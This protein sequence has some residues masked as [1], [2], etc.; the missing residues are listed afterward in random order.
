MF[1]TDLHL[2]RAL[3]AKTQSKPLALLQRYGEL[4]TQQEIKADGLLVRAE[5]AATDNPVFE[6]PR[7]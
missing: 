5:F 3:K 1:M 4:G 2:A 6:T 7:L